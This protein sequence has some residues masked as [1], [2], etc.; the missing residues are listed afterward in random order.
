M[1]WPVSVLGGVAGFVLASVPGALLGGVLGQWLDRH[2]EL[3]DWGDLRQR[4]GRHAAEQL[5]AVLLMHLLGAVA[6]VGV[7]RPA[8]Q[9]RALLREARRAGLNEALALAAFA[10]GQRGARIAQALAQLQPRPARRDTVLRAAWRMAWAGDCCAPPARELLSRWAEQLGCSDGHLAE[11][12]AG[13]L[14]WNRPEPDS[15]PEYRAALALLGVS[16]DSPPATIKRA[17]RRLLSRHHPDKL[18][19]ADA[20]RLA[21]ATETTRRLHAAWELIRQRQDLH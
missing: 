12:E 7:A 10:R 20:V 11:L 21:A 17:Y 9:R 18:G 13:A 4:L 5:D 15:D 8:A 3:A 19:A 14:G 16:A 6:A 1:L 2:L